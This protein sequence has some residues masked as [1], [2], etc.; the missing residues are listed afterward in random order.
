MTTFSVLIVGGG[1]AGLVLANILEKY[2]I[3]YS[4][5]EKHDAI[6]SD[7]GASVAIL[8]HGSRILDQLGC[9]H[10]LR[11]RGGPVRNVGTFGPD[12][13]PLNAKKLPED[14]LK[15]MSVCQRD[16]CTCC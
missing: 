15:T 3:E 13:K 16:R 14:Y 12:G 2:N 6:L 8:P 10:D 5:V 9:Y 11:A 1:V 7:L 4:L